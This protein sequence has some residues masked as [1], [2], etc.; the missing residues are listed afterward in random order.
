MTRS[1]TITI[2]LPNSALKQ[3]QE[4]ADARRVSRGIAAKEMLMDSLAK[5]SVTASI[6]ARLVRLED[7]VR[8][9]AD[10][11]LRGDPTSDDA[12]LPHL[13]SA[14]ATVFHR[15]LVASGQDDEEAAKWLTEV[16]EVRDDHAS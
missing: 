14:L 10:R 3:L 9:L 2:R 4:A 13:R 15:F 8:T 6:E 1:D 7:A 12:G 11:D 16:F 5:F